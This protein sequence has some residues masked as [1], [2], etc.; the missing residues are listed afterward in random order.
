MHV[1]NTNF[2]KSFFYRRHRLAARLKLLCQD[3]DI[4]GGVQLG[5]LICFFFIAGQTVHMNLRLPNAWKTVLRV[6]VTVRESSL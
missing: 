5:F 4:C 1:I 6:E 2:Q 3:Q